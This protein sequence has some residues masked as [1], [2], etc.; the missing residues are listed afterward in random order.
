MD[1]P[2]PYGLAA[3]KGFLWIHWEGWTLGEREHFLEVIEREFPAV[4]ADTVD[5][6]ERWAQ[7]LEATE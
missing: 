4:A 1:D 2:V 7:R 5:H 6:L 3:V